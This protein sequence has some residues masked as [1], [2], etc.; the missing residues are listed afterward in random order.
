MAGLGRR[1]GLPVGSRRPRR[2]PGPFRAEARGADHGRHAACARRVGGAGASGC[3]RR[4]GRSVPGEIHD[5]APDC[6]RF[7]EGLTE[8]GFIPSI[9]RAG[10]V[11]RRFSNRNRSPRRAPQRAPEGGRPRAGRVPRPF[12]RG[13]SVEAL[14]AIGIHVPD[15]AADA[16]RVAW[17]RH[18]S[19]IAP[20]VEESEARG[21]SG[22]SQKGLPG[23]IGVIAAP[24]LQRPIYKDQPH[25]RRREAGAADAGISTRTAVVLS[26]PEL[27]TASSTSAF[28]TA[29]SPGAEGCVRM[30]SSILRSQSPSTRPSEKSINRAPGPER[31]TVSYVGPDEPGCPRQATAARHCASGGCAPPFRSG[32]PCGAAIPRGCGHA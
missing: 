6:G 18:H 30:N 12:P 19:G 16:R 14:K 20:E 31:A 17:Q 1:V 10:R 5:G 27:C 4:A 7:P 2:D 13:V 8:S 29:G 28:D 21:R 22:F 32:R 26:R 25:G 9:P 15:F 24:A 23:E 11:L 3:A